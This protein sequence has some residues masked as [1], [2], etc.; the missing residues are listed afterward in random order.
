M[1]VN[2]F[3]SGDELWSA[4]G[5]LMAIGAI[6]FIIAFLGCCGAIKESSCMVLTVSYKKILYFMTELNMKTKL[7]N[8]CHFYMFIQFSV[9]LIVI[10]LF[11]I[12]IGAFGYVN[13]DEL[14]AALDKG[15]NKTLHN[16]Q[17][18]KEA[19]NTVQSELH[20][21][22]IL[23]PDDYKPIFNNTA[24]LPKSCCLNLAADKV[25]TKD[26]AS[27]FK[28]G[29]K[30]ALFTL[31]DS[32]STILAG[33]AVAVGLIQVSP[34]NFFLLSR[35]GILFI[36]LW[37]K[38]S[39]KIDLFFTDYWSWIRLLLVSCIPSKLWSRLNLR[40]ISWTMKT[41]WI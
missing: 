41:Y 17:P 29:C 13:K 4:P 10:I 1:T 36:N 15:F 26:D 40:Q 12:G 21:C 31:L 38:N 23:G 25:C 35:H 18:N 5:I 6:V 37:A 2:R 19:W 33:V 7:I 20:C 39:N 14:N 11:E 24:E 8:L 32:Q 27:C 9:L 3:I 16:Y 30:S 28:K 22:G 34:I